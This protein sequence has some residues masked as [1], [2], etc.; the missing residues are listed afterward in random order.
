MSND[1]NKA[2]NSDGMAP[3]PRWLSEALYGT[4][5]LVQFSYPDAFDEVAAFTRRCRE[6]AKIALGISKLRKEQQRIGF[7]PLP[8]ADYIQGLVKVSGVSLPEVLAKFGIKD[9]ASSDER[10]APTL[11]RL[12]KAVGIG[13]R[14]TLAHF[15]ISFATQLNTAPIPLLVARYRRTE[16]RQTSVDACEAVLRQ[17]ASQYDLSS[18]KELRRIEVGVRAVFTEEQDTPFA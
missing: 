16:P 18:L 2:L 11:A 9:L 8:F 10:S 4:S 1:V 6:G 14:E 17:L 7:V 13:L 12:A 5:G 15:N 3:P